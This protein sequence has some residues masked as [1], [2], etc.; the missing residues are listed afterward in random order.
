MELTFFGA[1]NTVTGSKTLCHYKHQKFLVD[2]GLF[3]GPKSKRELNWQL[4]FKADEVDFVILTHA[5]I[6]HS[7]ILPKL[8]REG[9]R[10]PI[11]CTRGTAQLL[12]ILLI[13]AAYLQ[14]EDAEYANKSGYSNHSPALPLYTIEDAEQVLKQIKILKRD[15]WHQ[16]YPDLGVRFLRAGHIIGSSIVQISF[17]AKEGVEIITFSGDLGN[18]RSEILL[19][20]VTIHE[21]DYLVLEATYGNKLQPRVSV[22]RE[23]QIYLNRVLNRGGVMIIPAFSV[24]RTQ[25]LLYH[26]H[27]LI[28][29]KLIP[30]VPIYVDSPMS[31]QAN[32]IFIENSDEHQLKIENDKL[33]SPICP[34]CYFE[35][36]DREESQKLNSKSGPMII[37]TASGMVTGGRVLHHLKNRLP[38]KSNGVMFV[39][40]QAEETKGRLL[41]EGINTIRIHHEEIPVNAEVFHVHG[42]SAHAD[43]LDMLDWLK[44]LK[45]PPKLIILN[46][47]EAPGLHNLK[48]VIE[49]SFNFKVTI[50]KV[51]E[52]FKFNGDFD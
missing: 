22:E 49:S 10:G 50:A 1:G 45:R 4:G 5:H 2:A 11:Y 42:M 14:E 40:F 29:Q 38:V 44:H 27:N 6:D 25:E 19:P 26:L 46:H 21:T 17:V 18:G 41:L 31:A 35:T 32:R 52:S 30:E 28:K 7:G 39:G 15:D 43:Y 37:I 51:K 20:P 47:G 12:R 9:F 33:V 3:Q 16:L 34:H 13:D 36:K 24:G 8:Y 48:R 23:M